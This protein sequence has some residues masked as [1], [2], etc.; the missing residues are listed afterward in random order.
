MYSAFL[1]GRRKVMEKMY[2]KA[3]AKINLNLLVLNKRKDNYHNI[4]SIFQKVS[5]YDELYVSKSNKDGIELITNVE[6]INNENNII[7]KAY[8]KLKE[9][10]PSISGVKVELNKRI[11]MQAGMAGGSTD[12]AS[13]ILC[14]NKLF[15][16]KLSKKE[17]EEIGKSLGADV[18]PCLY[19]KAVIAKGIG[20]I[21][22]KINTK[23]KYYILVIK[24]KAVGD[25]KDMYKRIDE[26]KNVEQL[27]NSSHIIKALEENNID[28]MKDNVYNV[29][30][31]V[32]KEK[33]LIQKIKNELKKHGAIESLMTGSGSCVYGL[34][35]SKKMVKKAYH[36]LKE[37]YQAYMCTSYNSEREE[38]F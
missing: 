2:M 5:L 37:K 33:S 12:C 30:E 14:M 15:D 24:P 27:D 8:N 1:K 7:C 32:I 3:R 13:F 20:D 9:R 38:M 17:I 19:N 11:P 23:F 29:F 25:T 21:I 10:F 22:T 28:L 34:F 4:K 31:N 26:G 6:E 36:K 18:V 16:L 35:K